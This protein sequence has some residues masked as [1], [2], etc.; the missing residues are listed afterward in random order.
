MQASAAPLP[1]HAGASRKP[2]PPVR[3]ACWSM[4]PPHMQPCCFS[5]PQVSVQAGRAGQC[6]SLAEPCFNPT[7][8]IRLSMQAN[9]QPCRCQQPRLSVGQG[10]QA[11]P[12]A[13]WI[14]PTAPHPVPGSHAAC[15]V[16]PQRCI[17]HPAPGTPAAIVCTMLCHGDGQ[18][19]NR[20]TLPGSMAAEVWAA[21]LGTRRLGSRCWR[22]G[23]AALQALGRQAPEQGFLAGAAGLCS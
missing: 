16:Q 22:H 19:T 13:M 11:S 5:C 3:W 23:Q 6:C 10:M 1:S 18:C 12:A 4:T 21:H 14:Q 20:T 7:P 2:H 15:Y 8:A 9:L 17:A